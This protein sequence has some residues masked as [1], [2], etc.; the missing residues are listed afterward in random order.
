VKRSV[1]AVLAAAMLLSAREALACPMCF[2]ANDNPL[3]QANGW[4]IATLLVVTVAM[5]AA[6]AA[7]FLTL[8][9]RA[10]NTAPP[11]HALPDLA[12]PLTAAHAPAGQR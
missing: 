12:S 1:V 9:R 6:F 4:G 2:G 8:R 3:V 7:F 11:E 5:L 10:Q